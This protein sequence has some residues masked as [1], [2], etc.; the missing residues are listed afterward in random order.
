M[1]REHRDVLLHAFVF[2]VHLCGSNGYVLKVHSVSLILPHCIYT[3]L[4]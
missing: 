3:V 4:L 2:S 1:H